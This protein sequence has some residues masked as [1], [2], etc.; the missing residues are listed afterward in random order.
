MR[1]NSIKKA[2]E[3]SILLAVTVGRIQKMKWLVILALLLLLISAILIIVKQECI[4][5]KEDTHESSNGVRLL[6][7]AVYAMIVLIY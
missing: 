5:F 1:M 7:L 2:L 4:D 3:Y 6:I